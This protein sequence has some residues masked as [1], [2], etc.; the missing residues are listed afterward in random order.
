VSSPR[1]RASRLK[2]EQALETLRQ[3]LILAETQCNLWRTGAELIDAQLKQLTIEATAL[4]DEVK[5]L[6]GRIIG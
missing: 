5:Q 3:K 2:A 1:K 6:K 4:R